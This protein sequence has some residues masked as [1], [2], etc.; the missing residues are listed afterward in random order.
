M[1]TTTLL[2]SIVQKQ[3]KAIRIV[4][5]TNYRAHTQPLFAKSKILPLHQLIELH[6]LKFM[7]RFAH[8]RQPFSY[9]DTWVTNYQRNPAIQLRNVNNFVIPPH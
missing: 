2:N 7:H 6:K 8:N 5:N 1:A 9:N 4:C 3:K